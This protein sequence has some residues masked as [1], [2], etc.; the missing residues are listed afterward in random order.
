MYGRILINDD[1]GTGKSLQAI[2]L[3]LAYR[4]EWPLLILCPVFAKFNWRQE[5]LK[6][7]PGFDIERIQVL[8]NEREEFR[9]NASILIVTYDLAVKMIWRLQELQLKVCIVDEAHWFSSGS[10]NMDRLPKINLN[11]MKIVYNMR[12]VILLSSL[13]CLAQPAR[14][15]S[16]AKILRP[17]LIPNFYE[18][19][20]RYCDP[21]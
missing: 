11:L 3:A 20:Y 10:K 4:M 12:R 5:I 7:L 1:F 13:N 14:L 21:R 15:H 8:Q 19:G 9:P 2:S 18:F 17:D 16:I 6:W